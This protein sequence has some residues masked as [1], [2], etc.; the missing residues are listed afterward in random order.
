MSRTRWML[1]FQ[2]AVIVSFART[3]IGKLAGSLS[4][5]TAPQ[6]GP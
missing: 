4:S 3:P 6:V 1:L 5:L 2:D